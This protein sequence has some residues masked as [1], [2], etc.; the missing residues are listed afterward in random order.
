MTLLSDMA[1]IICDEASKIGIKINVRQTDFQ[2]VIESMMSTF[3]W[4]SCIGTILASS[5]T[6]LRR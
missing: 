6:P 1:Q 5:S 3:D 4:Q 2:K